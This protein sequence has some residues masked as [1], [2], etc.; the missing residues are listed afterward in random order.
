[1]SRATSASLSPGGVTH[2]FFAASG[3]AT[4]GLTWKSAMAM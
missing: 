1:M 4:I 2:I 3:Q